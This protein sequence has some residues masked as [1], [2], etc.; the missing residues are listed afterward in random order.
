MGSVIPFS[1]AQKY[2]K[3]LTGDGH[4]VRAI[5]DTNVLIAGT[6]EINKAHETVSELLDGF[7]KLGVE[8]YA[9]VNTRSEF[10]EFH[11][12]L[13]LTEVLL[14]LID[15]HSNAKISNPARSEIK[16]A[17]ASIKSKQARDSVDPIFNDKQLKAIKAEFSAG[18]H[19]GHIGWLKLCEISLKGYI[20]QIDATLV[21]RGVEYLSPNDP[22]Q[23]HLFTQ[24][25][26]WPVAAA[27]V[28]KTGLSISDSMILNALNSSV[29]DFAI[30]LDFDFGFA[31]LADAKSKNV[32]MPDCAER[33]YRHYHFDIL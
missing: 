15:E 33:E 13:M 25:L 6:Y 31:T 1:Q 9:T 8:F 28:E 21:A 24:T 30:S 4:A 3:S 32:V 20:S 22:K 11:R 18:S 12:R 7:T 14:D 17:Y 5:I 29:C 23:A 27:I 19:S 10:M 2:V 16:T 26:D